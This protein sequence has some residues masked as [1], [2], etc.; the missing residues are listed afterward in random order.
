VPADPEDVIRAAIEAEISLEL[1]RS[2]DMATS[3]VPQR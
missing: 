3:S 2:R 1:Q